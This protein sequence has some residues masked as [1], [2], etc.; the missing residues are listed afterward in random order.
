MPR[1]PVLVSALFRALTPIAERDELLADLQAGMSGAPKSSGERRPDAGPG[2]RRSD[3]CPF[4]SVAA[5]G[6]A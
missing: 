4:S 6:A 5:G 2:S 1:L 3:R